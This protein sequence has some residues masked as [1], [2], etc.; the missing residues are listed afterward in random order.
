[1]TRGTA[2]YRPF[3]AYTKS[4]CCPFHLPTAQ[5]TAWSLVLHLHNPK[6]AFVFHLQLTKDH[7]GNILNVPKRKVAP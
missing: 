5:F 3:Q 1:M 4:N 6:L 2:E 7:E